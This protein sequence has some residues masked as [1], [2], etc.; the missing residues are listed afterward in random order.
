MEIV[1]K[2]V[3]FNMILIVLLTIIIAMIL[4]YEDTENSSSC[5]CNQQPENRSYTL[6]Y[7]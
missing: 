5:G 7:D 2:G 6:S 1:V 4:F 3:T